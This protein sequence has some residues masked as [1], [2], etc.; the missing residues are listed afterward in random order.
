MKDSPEIPAQLTTEVIS[1]LAL[2]RRGDMIAEDR[3]RDGLQRAVRPSPPSYSETRGPFFTRTSL[4]A[5][6]ESVAGIHS[7]PQP[8][9]STDRRSIR[10]SLIGRRAIAGLLTFERIQPRFA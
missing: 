7:V 3:G 1:T 6:S 2:S 5:T 4:N 8:D 9:S 10:P